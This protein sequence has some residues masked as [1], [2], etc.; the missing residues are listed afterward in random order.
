MSTKIK[1]LWN[2]SSLKIVNW[3][4]QVW[5]FIGYLTSFHLTL[6]VPPLILHNDNDPKSQFLF[7][8][9][10]RFLRCSLIYLVEWFLTPRTSNIRVC[11]ILKNYRLLLFCLLFLSD[12]W[13]VWMMKKS[14]ESLKRWDEW[15][16]EMVWTRGQSD[17][18]M[19]YSLHLS[20]NTFVVNF[21]THNVV[22][23]KSLQKYIQKA[24]NI[25]HEKSPKVKLMKIETFFFLVV[26]SLIFHF[27]SQSS[28]LW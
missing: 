7:G 3:W 20:S 1:N 21:S 5:K 28:P 10:E 4:W 12:Q 15:R 22:K 8:E 2:L 6:F 14:W 25:S 11:R 27:L 17:S 18:N 24:N 19:R 26:S 13:W 23:S 16:W 9:E